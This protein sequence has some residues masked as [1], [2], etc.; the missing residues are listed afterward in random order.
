M[1]RILRSQG[2]RP[3]A[4]PGY[5]RLWITGITSSLSFTTTTLGVGWL[6]LEITGSVGL[7]G[8]TAL[9]S[10]LTVISFTPFSSTLVDKY[11]RRNLLVGAQILQGSGFLILGAITFIDGFIEYWHLLVAS[12]AWGIARSA[13]MPARNA[14]TFDI[15][16]RGNILNAETLNFLAINISQLLGPIAAGFILDIWGPGS[17]FIVMGITYLAGTAI[18]LGVSVPRVST[19]T[20][21]LGWRALSAGFSFAFQDRE[22]RTVVWVVLVTELLGFA[23]LALLPAANRELLNGDA[24]MLGL[25][26]GTFGLGGLTATL[27]ITA[28]GGVRSR[29]WVLMG[30]SAMMGVSIIAF[31]QSDTFLLSLPFI[32][33]AGVSGTTYDV[34]NGTLF[35]TLTPEH[36]RGRVL[37]VR[38]MLMSGSQVGSGV[39]GGSAERLGLSLALLIAGTSIAVNALRVIPVARTINMRSNLDLS[40]GIPSSQLSHDHITSD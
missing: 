2:L 24:R 28:I 36:I 22:T 26:S 14:L 35:Q 34:M 23:V 6:V 16:G 32:F 30:A 25:L 11:N 1:K 40:E 13:M 5:W 4:V 31:S 27:T 39:I 7:L 37:G 8:L 3:F 12:I 18:L 9:V 10:G 33:L 17:F 21:Q 20:T 29:A 19:R 38:S 15:V